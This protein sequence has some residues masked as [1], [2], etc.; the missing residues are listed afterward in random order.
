MGLLN[1]L[2]DQIRTFMK[3][4]FNPQFIDDDHFIQIMSHSSPVRIPGPVKNP[5]EVY[6]Q[7]QSEVYS[8][9]VS[10]IPSSL[11]VFEV[12]LYEQGTFPK[13]IPHVQFSDTESSSA[14]LDVDLDTE[15]PIPTL[16]KKREL[17]SKSI[18][19]IDK[20]KARFAKQNMYFHKN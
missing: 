8:L 7:I 20:L 12:D 17:S 9:Q 14:H 6:N 5:Y 15:V 1:F 10:P 4:I 3:S 13:P 2:I 18:H 11:D 16:A 19:Q